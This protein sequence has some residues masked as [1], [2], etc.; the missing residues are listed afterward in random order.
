M[1][2]PTREQTLLDLLRRCRRYVE[3]DAQMM[4]D[5]SRHAPLDPASQATHD[6]TE[7]E[8]EK[9]LPLIDAALGGQSS[10]AGSGAELVREIGMRLEH[11]PPGQKSPCRACALLDRLRA[12]LISG[13]AAREDA[14]RMLAA[15]QTAREYIAEREYGEEWISEDWFDASQRD[16]LKRID[17]AIDR[18]RGGG[19]A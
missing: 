17:A 12:A 1:T 11:D 10:G 18:A 8:S 6:T 9:L 3:A 2:A 5:I 15:L 13:D 14:E 4:A 7:Y 19:D 16:I